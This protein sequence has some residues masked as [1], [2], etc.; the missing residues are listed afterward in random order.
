MS[1]YIYICVYQKISLLSISPIPVPVA[2]LE[3]WLLLLGVISWKSPLSPLC[4]ENAKTRWFL[5]YRKIPLLPK[6]MFPQKCLDWIAL[7]NVALVVVFFFP[8][9]NFCPNKVFSQKEADLK[10]FRRNWKDMLIKV[11]YLTIP[12]YFRGFIRKPLLLA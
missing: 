3:Q 5:M 7:N 10:V 11:E 6:L 1:L 12:K 2:V 4:K 9:V 8:T